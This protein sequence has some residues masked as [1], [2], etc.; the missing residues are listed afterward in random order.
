MVAAPNSEE[1]PI[2][3]LLGGGLLSGFFKEFKS[4]LLDIV[5]PGLFDLFLPLSLLGALSTLMV[6]A[7]NS[8]PFFLTHFM[9]R[10]ISLALA[11]IDW[12]FLEGRMESSFLK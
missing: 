9:A 10:T 11:S 7:P 4:G 6:A 3:G 12:P 8:K 2:P 1:A 5:L